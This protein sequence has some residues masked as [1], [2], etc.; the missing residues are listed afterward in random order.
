MGKMEFTVVINSAQWKGL[1]Q[2]LVLAN[3][4]PKDLFLLPVWIHNLNH[5]SVYHLTF[6]CLA[7]LRAR[8]CLRTL[9]P[10]LIVHVLCI[11]GL[12]TYVIKSFE[13]LFVLFYPLTNRFRFLPHLFFHIPPHSLSVTFHLF[14]PWNLSDLLQPASLLYLFVLCVASVVLRSYGW[15]GLKGKVCVSVSH[16]QSLSTI[17]RYKQSSTCAEVFL[18]TRTVSPGNCSSAPLSLPLSPLWSRP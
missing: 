5:V 15:V 9:A 2:P 14:Y 11:V 6:A 7:G 3:Q 16:T 1:E 12:S 13:P 18:P 17:P 10:Y 4:K 8:L